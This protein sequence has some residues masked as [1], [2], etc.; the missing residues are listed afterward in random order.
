[1]RYQAVLCAL[2]GTML[3]AASPSGRVFTPVENSADYQSIAALHKNSQDPQNNIEP[4]TLSPILMAHTKTLSLAFLE[5][6]GQDSLIIFEEVLMRKPG[7]DWRRIWAWGINGTNDCQAGI[8]HYTKI[9]R[10][11]K[12]RGVNSRNLL[13]GF[14]RIVENA[15]EGIECQFGD[16]ESDDRVLKQ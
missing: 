14:E 9:I 4:Y 6:R 5:A 15:H 13:P 11:V 16:F 2:A 10:Y 1:M 7:S 3:M 8:V 12:R